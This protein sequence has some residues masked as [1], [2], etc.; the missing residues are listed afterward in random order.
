MNA[1]AK[2]AVRLRSIRLIALKSAIVIAPMVPSR[3]FERGF[4]IRGRVRT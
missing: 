2:F 3:S 4:A 1:A